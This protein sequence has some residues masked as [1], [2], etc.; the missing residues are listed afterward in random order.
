MSYTGVVQSQSPLPTTHARRVPDAIRRWRSLTVHLPT[1]LIGEY[2]RLAR[3][4]NWSRIA[5]IRECLEFAGLPHAR[6]LAAKKRRETDAA[7]AA[8]PDAAARAET[9]APAA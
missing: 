2:T 3:E 7:A 8:V 1:W 4:L 9:A 5:L 6:A